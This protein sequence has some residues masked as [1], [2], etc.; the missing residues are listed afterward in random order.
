[1]DTR[2]LEGMPSSEWPRPYL[3]AP[4]SVLDVSVPSCKEVPMVHVSLVCVEVNTTW[5]S[6]APHGDSKRSTPERRSSKTSTGS[7]MTDTSSVTYRLAHGT[8]MDPHPSLLV[9]LN[10]PICAFPIIQTSAPRRTAQRYDHQS[11]SHC[12]TTLST[13][14]GVPQWLAHYRTRTRCR[15]CARII[16]N[17]RACSRPMA[18]GEPDSSLPFWSARDHTLRGSL[19]L[20]L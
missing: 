17:S 12:G 14:R 1:M 16:T 4:R 13:E 20:M 9:T 15:T 3:I 10:Q 8:Q 6:L 18:L 19:R 11:A 2:E 5:T 7:T